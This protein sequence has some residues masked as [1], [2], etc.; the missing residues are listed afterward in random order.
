MPL[1]EPVRSRISYA[2]LAQWPDDGRRYEIYDGE[3][4]VVPSPLPLHQRV[5]LAVAY[6]LDGH[7]A[8][9]NGEAIISPI[10]IV[11]SDYNVLQP[12]VVY[13]LPDRRD[14]VRP[15]A[16]IRDRPDIAVE[17]LSHSTS[18]TDRGRKMEL[19]ARY[20]LPEYW[21]I[22]PVGKTCEVYT[23]R[24]GSL[25]L[26]QTAHAGDVVRSVLLLELQFPLHTLFERKSG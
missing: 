23:L 24:E 11:L 4:Q 10:D 15:D 1:V 25:E 19:L 5:A 16:A 26:A 18:S 7:P 17:V 13:F 6:L 22:D 8:S 21:L 9:R 2:E 20:G 14:V 3:V 12:D